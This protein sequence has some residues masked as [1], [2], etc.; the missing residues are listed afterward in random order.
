MTHVCL[1]VCYLYLCYLHFTEIFKIY[2]RHR[3]HIFSP[4]TV[5]FRMLMI[6][7]L[8]RNLDAYDHDCTCKAVAPETISSQKN[9]VPSDLIP[10]KEM[11]TRFA[12]QLARLRYLVSHVQH[13]L[14][15]SLN[16]LIFC[17]ASYL[18]LWDMRVL[19][20]GS[21]DTVM[22]DQRSIKGCL[23]RDAPSFVWEIRHVSF[24]IAFSII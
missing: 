11:V 6:T 20:K 18:V 4:T 19:V 23:T 17:F 16:L 2:Y 22:W 7:Y 9:A 12:E 21:K 14:P 10:M 15:N 3:I 13:T 8:K 24:L 5:F 1:C